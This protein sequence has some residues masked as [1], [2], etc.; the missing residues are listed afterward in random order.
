VRA[1]VPLVGWEGGYALG[2]VADGVV[3]GFGGGPS[4]LVREGR[5]P[6]GG[7][8]ERWWGFD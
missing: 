7:W 5:E 1:D 4:G 8:W 6:E 3:M 2:E